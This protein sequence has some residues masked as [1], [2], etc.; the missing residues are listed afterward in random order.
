MKY[1]TSYRA[2][3]KA[4]ARLIAAAPELLRSLEALLIVIEALKLEHHF[5]PGKDKVTGKGML[6]TAWDVIDKATSSERTKGG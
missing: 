4:N 5:L 2:W 6:E 1:P 3:I